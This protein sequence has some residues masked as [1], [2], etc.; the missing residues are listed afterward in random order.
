M[1]LERRSIASAG[2]GTVEE[3]NR[4][5]R[6]EVEKNAAIGEPRASEPL[7]RFST[8]LVEVLYSPLVAFVSPS[9]R[10]STVFFE[11]S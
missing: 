6:A 8:G 5:R 9:L 3:F 11:A 1:D 10:A 7:L 4:P 2:T